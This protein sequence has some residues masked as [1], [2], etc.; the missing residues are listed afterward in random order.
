MYEV[1]FLWALAL[2]YIIFAVIQ[3]L[4]TREIA[5]WLTF[6]LVIFALVFR[7]F[8]SLFGKDGFSFFFSG[9]IGFA[10]FFALGNLFYYARVF[11]GGDAKLMI[12]LGAVL[13]ISASLSSNIFSFI[14]FLLIFLFSGFAYILIASVVLCIKN[15]KPFVN[16]FRR[17]MNKNKKLML[18]VDAFGGVFLLLGFVNL[19]F[20]VFGLL[21]IFIFY[22]YLFS[23]SI[24]EVCMIRKIQ[25]IHLR[26]GD[27]LYSDVKIGKNTIKASWDG[28]S[29]KEIA[30]IKKRY[31]QT[32]I[33]QGIPFSPN[34]LISF[35]FF[36]LMKLFNVHLW[37]SLW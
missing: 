14:T 27:W 21:A 18:I 32:K 28:L 17:Q 25:S 2:V 5:N 30:E 9:L 36:I 35:I 15:F 12:A 22:L 37:N 11:A 33:R 3:D 1:I 31:K 10:I 34:F 24:D 26:E 6:S 4:K 29:K 7:F 16:E 20:L 13:P 23:K 19:S 8:Y